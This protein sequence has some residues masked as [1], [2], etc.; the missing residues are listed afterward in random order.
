VRF[1]LYDR[2]SEIGGGRIV[3]TKAFTLSEEYLD[4]HFDRTPAV[5][6]TI[7]LE[8]MLQLLGWGIIH[9][10]DFDLAAI[11]SL[12]EGVT[13]ADARLHPGFEATITGEIVSTSPS[14][15]LGRA[16]LKVG[17]R[18]IASAERVIYSH[19]PAS[20]PD[21]LRRLFRYC[22]GRD[23]DRLPDTERRP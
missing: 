15:S 14:D 7:L 3:G 4:A 23:L 9:A 2:V 17:G 19:F 6:G 13:I 8:A 5:P 11:V 10:H 22:S 1:L 18:R 12:V 20:S 16:W 21:A